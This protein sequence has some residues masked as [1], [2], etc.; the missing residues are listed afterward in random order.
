[1]TCKDYP[2]QFSELLEILDIVFWSFGGFVVIWLVL[3]GLG[4]FFNSF[5]P[6]SWP[7]PVHHYSG[8][9]NAW[10]LDIISPDA[11][12]VIIK[13]GRETTMGEITK[14]YITL[15][16]RRAQFQRVLI[17][18]LPFKTCS[19]KNAQAGWSASCTDDTSW[20]NACLCAFIWEAISTLEGNAFPQMWF[21]YL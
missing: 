3:F 5:L 21:R 8:W 4:F 11:H 18:R 13:T 12:F 2:F 6:S 16:Q 20:A 9:Q 10:P 1:M 14:K 15:R 17:T 19:L 7:L